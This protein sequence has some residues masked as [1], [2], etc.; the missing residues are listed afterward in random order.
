MEEERK[1][2]VKSVGYVFELQADVKKK[3]KGAYCP[4][5]EVA[6]NP[7][8]EYVQYIVMPW[9]NQFE[10]QRDEKNGGNK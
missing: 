9:F 2:F 8:I 5:Q 10:V 6:G 3:I 7:C 4:P 1:L